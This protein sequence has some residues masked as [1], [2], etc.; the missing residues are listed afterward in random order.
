MDQFK[1]ISPS[2]CT[3]QHGHNK[4]KLIVITGGPGAGKTAVLELARKQ[5]CEHIAIMPEA[6]SIIF[7]GGFWRLN[8]VSAKMASQRAI[9][10]VQ[11]ELE[12]LV[13][14]EKNWAVGICDRG[15]IDGL[16]YWPSEEA[17]Y[18]KSLETSQQKQFDKYSLVIHLRTPTEALG[19]NLQNPIRIETA[20]EAAKI[21]ARIAQV[22]N[23]HPN[24]FQVDSATNFLEKAQKAIGLISQEIPL[25]CRQ[26]A[27]LAT[28]QPVEAA[29]PQMN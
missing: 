6:A 2:T 10:Y 27:R 23:P 28:N 5:L 14:N 16:A 7:G 22:W 4:T 9:F 25:C 18:W 13:L 20:L 26:T 21:D 29:R 19:Y 8:S 12:N 24:Y 15:T 3:C 11:Q 17:A 1:I